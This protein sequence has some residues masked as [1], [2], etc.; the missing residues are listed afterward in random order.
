MKVKGEGGVRAAGLRWIGPTSQPPAEFGPLTDRDLEA[1]E[2]CADPQ[3]D[4]VSDGADGV[5]ALP[6][7]SFELP[8]L[9][10]GAGV[11]G[12]GLAAAHGDEHLGGPGRSRQSMGLVYSPVMSVPASA[13]AATAEPLTSVPGSDPPDQATARSPTSWL[14]QPSPKVSGFDHG[15]LGWP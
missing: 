3:F 9:V 4:V 13:M 15:L 10:P 8:A 6:A 11:E 2:E 14:N 1:G 7:G 12:A 5:D